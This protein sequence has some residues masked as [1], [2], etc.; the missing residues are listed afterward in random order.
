MKMMEQLMQIYMW[1]RKKYM[2]E[3]VDPQVE[4][5]CDLYDGY[6]NLEN[7]FLQPWWA[8]EKEYKA[9]FGTASPILDRRGLKK[10]QVIL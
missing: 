9:M 1:E 8:E 2:Q 4:L 3:A 5:C 6:G 10:D 7:H